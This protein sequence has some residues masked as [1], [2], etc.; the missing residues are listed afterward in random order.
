[1][2]VS[3]LI[4]IELLLFIQSQFTTSDAQVVLHLNQCTYGHV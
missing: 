1:M 3:N 4:A 2:Y